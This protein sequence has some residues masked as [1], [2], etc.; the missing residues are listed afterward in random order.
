MHAPA[1]D[2]NISVITED[3]YFLQGFTTC[4]LKCGVY[5]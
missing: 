4:E 1:A 2:G 5:L 3:T